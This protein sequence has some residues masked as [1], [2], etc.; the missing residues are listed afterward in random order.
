MPGRLETRL[1]LILL[2]GIAP[3]FAQLENWISPGDLSSPHQELSG[4]KNCTQCHATAKGVPDSKCLDCHT[5]IK[6]RLT[7]KKGYHAKQSLDCLKCHNEHEGKNYD[8]TGLSR[9]DFNHDETGW[10]LEGR[11][12]NV[13]C[14]DCHTQKRKHS[15]TGKKLNRTTYLEANRLCQDCHKDIHRSK[16]SVFKRCQNCHT[17][18]SWGKTKRKLR[19]NH[20]RQ[21]NYKLTGAHKSVKCYDCHKEKTWAPLAHKKCTNCHTDPHRGK[22]GPKCTNCHTTKS[23]TEGSKGVSRGVKFGNFNHQKTRFPLTGQHRKVTCKRCHGPTIG[24]MKNFQQCSNCH[25]NP[26]GNQFQVLWKKKRC[27]DCHL[28]DGWQV[29]SFQ[30]NKDSRYK[31]VDQHTIVS[32]E[33]CHVDRKYRMYKRRPD[34]A[35]CHYDVHKGQFADKSCGTCHNQKGFSVLLFNHNKQ[36]RFPLVG[37]HEYT[38]CQKCHETGKYKPINTS[39]KTCHNDFHRGELGNRCTTCHSP[40]AFNN[41]DFDHNRSSRFP[42]TGKHKEIQCNQCHKDYKYKLN[43]LECNQCHIDVHKNSFGDRCERCHNTN[44]FSVGSG[45]HDFGEYSLGGVH[46]RLNCLVC[47]GPK[48]KV[49]PSLHQCAS[50]HKDPHMNSFGNRCFTCHGQVSWLP[51]TFRHKQ[52]GFELSGAHRFVSCDNCHA[53]RVFGGLPQECSFCHLDNFA[54]ASFIPQHQLGNTQCDNCHRTYGW[55]PTR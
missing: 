17:A 55:R 9:L 37:K 10:A 31:L 35:S 27:E 36:A 45:F 53:N 33:Q 44:N 14:K 24:K 30:H 38:P 7:T 47:H 43:L 39:C 54:A 23:W 41:I 3:A 22:L 42:L 32:C 18:W 26:H 13:E 8:I 49:R 34:C 11:H 2:L 50:C 21:T 29:L 52:T 5:E 40:Q 25:N 15:K 46:D 4:I 48:A 28:T 51:S 20:N 19:F 1:L 6:K 12:R 16:K